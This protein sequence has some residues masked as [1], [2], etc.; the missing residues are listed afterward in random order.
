MHSLTKTEN[1]MKA[2]NISVLLSLLLFIAACDMEVTDPV[3]EDPQDTVIPNLQFTVDTTYLDSGGN[4][5][6]ASGTV[7][8]KGSAKVSSP[9]YVEAQFYTSKTGNT[10]LG[11]NYTQIGVPIST[12]QSSFWTIY[13]TSSNVDV[14]NYPNFG[15]K[16]LRGIYK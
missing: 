10:K 3:V 8:N 5:L 16:D 6:V 2:L 14:R 11:G 7:T 12:N 9:W 4:R 13:Y 1:I 15:V